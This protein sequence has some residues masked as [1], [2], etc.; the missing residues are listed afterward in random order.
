MDRQ[1]TASFLSAVWPACRDCQ[2]ETARSASPSSMPRLI[3][4]RSLRVTRRA[5]PISDES[6][7]AVALATQVRE[8][9]AP[10]PPK[11]SRTRGNYPGP[12]NDGF[13]KIIRFCGGAGSRTHVKGPNRNE[14]RRG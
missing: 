13:G 2:R 5:S 8:G 6:E 7:R 12:L 3:G 1:S 9:K 11:D 14:A 4:K 10:R